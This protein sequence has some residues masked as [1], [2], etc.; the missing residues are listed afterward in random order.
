[1]ETFRPKNSPEF[2]EFY[3][4]KASTKNIFWFGKTVS[5]R[6]FLTVNFYILWANKLIGP[7]FKDTW[8]VRVRFSILT[9]KM[10]NSNKEP[11]MRFTGS[12]GIKPK[13]T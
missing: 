10:K 11:M 6:E 9:G 2:L 7:I 1:M 4:N 12:L 8:G 5:K 13:K 3:R